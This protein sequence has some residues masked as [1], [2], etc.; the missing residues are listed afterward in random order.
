MTDAAQHDPGADLPLPGLDPEP[1][2]RPVSELERQ[3]RR[4]LQ[5]LESAGLLE[6]RHAALAE[7]FLVLARAIDRQARNL[8]GGYAIA[9]LANS[10]R[11]VW[12]QLLPEEEGG[13]GSDDFTRWQRELAG[14]DSTGGT[15]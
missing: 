10:M 1:V 2:N 14:M 7:L 9:N 12:V 4:S 15:P 3:A 13:T 5:A 11:E 8:K 6:P